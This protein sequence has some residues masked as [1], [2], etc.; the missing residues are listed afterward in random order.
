M[1]D[2]VISSELGTMT[3]PPSK[4]R[5]VLGWRPAG[6]DFV[7]DFHVAGF[8]LKLKGIITALSRPAADGPKP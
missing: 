2:F 8:E 1:N 5:T 7:G 4:V 6:L 3:S